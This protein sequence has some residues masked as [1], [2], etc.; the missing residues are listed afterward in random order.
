M[1][2]DAWNSLSPH[3]RAEVD[4]HLHP[5]EAVLA[6]FEA[7]LDA[8]QRYAIALVVLTDQRCL[9]FDGDQPGERRPHSWQLTD[10]VDLR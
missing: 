2:A 4:A 5:G 10:G 9:S 6:W 8:H 7:D 3:L 1:T